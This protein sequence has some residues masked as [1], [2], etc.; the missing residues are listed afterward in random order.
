[1]SSLT[2]IVTDLKAFRNDIEYSHSVR[3]KI[4][5]LASLGEAL[6]IENM[7]ISK[8]KKS[9][10]VF[11]LG[12]G[13]SVN[14][15]NSS[16]WGHISQHDS[17]GFNFWLIHEHTPTF[18]F[19]E[20]STDDDRHEC[21]LK[22]LHL[23]REKYSAVPLI[24]EF[25]WWEGSGRTFEG[26]P[27]ELKSNVHLYAPYYF[28]F[29]YPFLVYLALTY[30]RLEGCFGLNSFDNVIHHRATLS[31]LVMFSM[32]AGYKRIVMVGIDLSNTKYFWED[33]PDSYINLPKPRNVET[34]HLHA[35]IDP[36]LTSREWAIPIDKFLDFVDRIILEPN[37]I[38]LFIGSQKSKLYPRFPLYDCFKSV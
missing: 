8:L 4:R 27:E 5:N 10:T 37:N 25:K 3:N 13:A 33:K 7:N 31:A 30:W 9:D 1:M 36:G 19:F 15:L 18:Y 20:P 16:D 34:G 26:F 14:D 35:T 11:I 12:S 22:L 17:I 28:R 6:T 32:L 24:C 21:F 23:K 38:E 29:R 2:N